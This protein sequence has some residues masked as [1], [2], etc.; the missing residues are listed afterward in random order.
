MKKFIRDWIKGN[1]PDATISFDK[2]GN[3]Y[4]TRGNEETYPCIVA[5]LDQVQD[6][7]SEDFK[8]YETE[9]I[10]I[11]F[12]PEH[13]EQQGLGADDKVGIWIGLQCLQRFDTIKLAFFV[14]EEIGCIGSMNA[15]ID[16]FRNCRFV[17]QPDRRGESDLITNIGWTTLCSE[18]FLKDI[19][20]KDFGY[21]ET[22]G[23]MTDVE[24]LK[25]RGIEVSCIN[26]SCGYYEPHSDNE[27]VYKP[28]ISNCLSFIEHVIRTCTKVYPHVDDGNGRYY[29]GLGYKDYYD[30][31]YNIL[32][33][34]P[35]LS[36]GDIECMFRDYYG[37]INRDE[38]ET[39]YEMAREDIFF[40]SG[41]KEKKDKSNKPTTNKVKALSNCEKD[42]DDSDEFYGF[43]Y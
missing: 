18:E 43:H 35:S 21:T 25:D 37:K 15:D 38:L 34:H 17:I 9:D 32:S 42:A 4:V 20:H 23:M 16:F 2:N 39:V 22:E 36:F 40:W 6:R 24:T 28:A 11:G 3:M 10:I 29:S 7:H 33:V 8:V 41:M 26:L 30:E 31:I 5:H 14:E 27:F 13:K 12:S 19:G 1:V